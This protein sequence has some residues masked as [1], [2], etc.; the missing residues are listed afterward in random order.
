MAD[1][2]IGWAG[3]PTRRKESGSR[4]VITQM[5]GRPD[6]LNSARVR[7]GSALPGRGATAV[8]GWRGRASGGVPRNQHRV[9]FSRRRLRSNAYKVDRVW[10]SPYPPNARPRLLGGRA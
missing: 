4:L 2:R 7:L 9:A 5:S 8:P 1:A 10:S 3:A 6:E